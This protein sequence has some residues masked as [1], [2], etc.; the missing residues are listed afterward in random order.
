MGARTAAQILVAR[1]G[2]GV[3]VLRTQPVACG[4]GT[5]GAHHGLEVRI[6]AHPRHLLD[7][8]T[9]QRVADVGVF[10]GLARRRRQRR[11]HRE[12]DVGV[13]ADGGVVVADGVGEACGVGQEVMNGHAGFVLWNAVEVV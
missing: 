11:L 6:V 7:D 13:P 1:I 10:V 5:D 3:G 8:G 2:V 4:L 12:A 9:E